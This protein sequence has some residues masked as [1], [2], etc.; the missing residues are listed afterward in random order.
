MQYC[1]DYP[2]LAVTVDAAVFKIEHATPHILL[3]LRKRAPYKGCWALPGGFVEINETLDAAAARELSEETGLINISLCQ[4]Y[5]FGNPE[6]DPRGHTISV[7]Y[8]GVC[9][10]NTIVKASDDAAEAQWFS[11]D[12]LPSL[13]FDHDL[14]IAKAIEW[15][16]VEKRH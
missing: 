13:A 15:L 3:I 4:L 5:T 6:R 16:K 11:I 9:E 10:T 8:V 14:I 1:Y 7:A 12:S 2:R